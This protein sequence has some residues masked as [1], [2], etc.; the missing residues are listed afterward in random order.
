M[1]CVC[2]G[3]SC[4]VMSRFQM[5]KLRI[6][7]QA[8][9]AIKLTAIALPKAEMCTRNNSLSFQAHSQNHEKRL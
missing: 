3:Y 5:Q 8:F 1:M 9:R 6:A 4:Y 2:S 7:K